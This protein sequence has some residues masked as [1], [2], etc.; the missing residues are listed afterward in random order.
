MPSISVIIPAYHA[1]KFIVRTVNSLL[2]QS[3][4]D[5]EAIIVSDD[6]F[7]YQNFLASKN[8]TDKRLRF[9]STSKIGSGP[10]N[11]RNI[12]LDMAKS[13]IIA[14]LDADD[15]FD[16]RK[17][18]MMIPMAKEHGIAISN[19][20]V[21]DNETNVELSNLQYHP[22]TRLI[23]Y[24]EILA[25]TSYGHSII[26][27]KKPNKNLY[28][29]TKVKRCEDLLFMTQIY[30][31]YGK[32]FYL[33][34]KLHNYYFH[35]NSLCHTQNAANNFFRDRNKIIYML[36]KDG[37]NIQNYH[38]KDMLIDFLQAG[39]TISNPL[40]NKEF[41]YK[42]YISELRKLCPFLPNRK[43]WKIAK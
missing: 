16:K 38:I 14:T 4:I 2:Q 3:L 29:P 17:L 28:W 1:E 23:E 26:V 18:A 11:A 32:A 24:N 34:H 36:R 31:Y 35:K 22:R 7:D 37:G 30:D 33:Q 20:R 10:S 5:W 12:A 6:S 15:T 41:N 39:I 42:N 27:Y 25:A 8:I 40:D 13:N 19:I 21:I 43:N 9:G